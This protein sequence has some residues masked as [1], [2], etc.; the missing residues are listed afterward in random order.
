MKYSAFVINCIIYFVLTQKE[1]FDAV[2]DF[3]VGSNIVESL[4]KNLVPQET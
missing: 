4:Y 2:V 1:N 3:S